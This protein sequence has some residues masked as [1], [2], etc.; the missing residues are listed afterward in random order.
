MTSINTTRHLNRRITFLY[1]TPTLHAPWVG[2]R[3]E[4]ASRV[5]LDFSYAPDNFLVAE[6]FF[7]HRICDAGL[8]IKG[9]VEVKH[10][11]RAVLCR[12]LGRC[13]SF[14][15]VARENG[16]QVVISGVFAVCCWRPGAP[17]PFIICELVVYV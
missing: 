1:R 12:N 2:K 6:Q 11:L 13:T 9:N 8:L 4:F 5:P 15:A 3:I 10:R 16:F 17:E 14:A 7:D